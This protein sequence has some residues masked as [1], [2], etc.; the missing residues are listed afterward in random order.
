MGGIYGA[1]EAD[2]DED[3]GGQNR[4]RRRRALERASIFEPRSDPRM[5]IYSITTHWGHEYS[6]SNLL[7]FVKKTSMLYVQ[8]FSKTSATHAH[9]SRTVGV[10][11]GVMVPPALHP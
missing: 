2:I 10:K 3:G 1:V 7:S 8:R 11:Y 9:R 5:A 6:M 4:N